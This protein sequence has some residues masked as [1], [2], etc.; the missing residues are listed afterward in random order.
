MVL[1]LKANLPDNPGSLVRMLKPI[2]DNGGNIY[3]VIHSHGEGR[4]GKVPVS[5]QFDL[6]A[7]N[8]DAKLQVIKKEFEALSIDIIELAQVLQRESVMA[9]LIGHVFETDFVDTYKRISNVGGTITRIEALFTDQK[10]IS[11]VK[12]EIKCDKSRVDATIEELQAICQ[13]KNLSILTDR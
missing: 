8:L 4:G 5:V 9:I 13:E 2:S 12:L 11:N 10:K 6:S 3:S 7:E 1:E